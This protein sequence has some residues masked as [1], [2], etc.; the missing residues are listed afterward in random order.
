MRYI[1]SRRSC[2]AALAF[3]IA[4]PIVGDA[5]TYSGHKW[6]VQQVSYYVNPAN[7]DVSQSAALAA[8]Q[9]GAATWG[10]QSN[11]N[12]SFYYMGQT[13]GSSFQGNYK[14]EVFFRNT[15]NGS[16]IAETYRWYDSAGTLLDADI[17]FYDGYVQFFTGSSGCSSGQYIEDIASHEFGHALG[18]SHSSVA[19]ATM[20]PVAATCTT[21]WRT[22][23][24]DD[25][26]GVE[27]LYPS[28]GST[29]TTTNT[30]PSVSITSPA[31]SASFLQG[32]AIPFAGSATDKEDGT[33]SSG[34]VWTSSI[35]G[36]F[37]TGSSLSIATLSAGTH[38]ITAS[39]KD[40]GGLTASQS[41]TVVITTATTTTSGIT[42]RASG[43]KVKGNQR[44][45]LSWSGAS[46]TY[47]D[48]YRNGALV[49]TTPNDGLQTDPIDNKGGG[50]Y[51]Y[52]VCAS[53]TSTCSSAVSVVF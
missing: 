43:Y 48:V 36:Q 31:N 45:D 30:A 47:V 3:L 52:K 21:S 18:L 46:S 39:V 11:A 35:N 26:A 22:L 4:V 15:T 6:S 17:A 50:S 41:I 8:V 33:I 14:N 34:L 32:V 13:S 19:S 20:Y 29:T 24:T 9:A 51:S 1:T 40:S 37:G 7:A 28:S 25:L 5:Y 10:T 38:T 49:F 44:V 42:L 53:G 12:F 27:Y 2:L 23:D 16:L